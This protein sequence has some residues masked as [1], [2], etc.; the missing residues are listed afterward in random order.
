[1]ERIYEYSIPYVIFFC[2]LF[3][4]TYI[5]IRNVDAQ[6]KKYSV[7][8]FAFLLILCFLGL[9]GFIATDWIAYYNLFDELPTF[10]TFKWNMLG[11]FYMEPGFIL[12]S[13][14]FK[15]VCPNYFAWVFV[16]TLIDLSVFH[17]LFKKYSK[18][19]LL[20]FLF[21]YL[22]LFLMEVNLY[23]NMK[24]IVLFLLSLRCITNGRWWEY[25]L[26]NIA[27]AFF[28]ISSL[29]F[30]ILYPFFKLKFKHGILWVIFV[31]GNILY[32]FHVEWCSSLI[33]F[34]GNSVG[35]ERFSTLLRYMSTGE[36]SIL[37]I[38]Y[39]E[40][41]L[42]FI[43][44]VSLKDRIIAGDM[45]RNIVYNCYILYFIFLFYFSEINVLAERF[46]GLFLFS[47]CFIFPWLFEIL[48]L[49]KTIFIVLL[50]MYGFIKQ[51]TGNANIMAKYSNLLW[52]IESYEERERDFY[53]YYKDDSI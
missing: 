3:V 48:K 51:V 29:L 4:F 27:G 9:R 2:V 52:G 6:K 49:N 40:R 30:I 7:R 43:L 46:S 32:L 19:Y 36:N 44:M 21:F 12:Y 28:H 16:N 17:F 22:F 25:I 1:M 33:E 41:L 10:G 37:S 26:W 8:S 31:V 23:R 35:L 53:I 5:D 38:G 14:F 45:L 13:I 42:T 24:S 34:I 47:Y 18:Y 11:D 20:S 15:T 50:F 39:F